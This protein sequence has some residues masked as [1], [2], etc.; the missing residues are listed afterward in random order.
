MIVRKLRLRKGWSQDQL[1]E[2]A[3]VSVRT[4]QRIE[5]GHKPS[6]ETANALAA[7]FEVEVTTFITEHEFM[8][9]IEHDEP[10]EPSQD[11]LASDEAEALEYA[12]G[13]KDFLSGVVAYLVLA[14][15]F[16]A[17][18][19]TSEPALFWVF[20]GVGL[21]LIV[22][23]LITFEVVRLPFQNLERKV[24]EKRLGRKL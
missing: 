20:G 16:F 19:G 6:L 10:A 2:L 23:G 3:D 12:K 18:K 22:Q 24:A 13:V 14:A 21:G 17:V 5:R 11:E 8:K 4:I 1:A 15:V 7:V 9:S